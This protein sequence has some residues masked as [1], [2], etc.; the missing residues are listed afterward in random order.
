MKQALHHFFVAPQTPADRV[1]RA[2]VLAFIVLPIAVM[3]GFLFYVLM[4]DF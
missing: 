2:N 1:N 4:F 3:F